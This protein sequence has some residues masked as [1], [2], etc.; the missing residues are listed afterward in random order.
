M[1][2]VNL[3]IGGVA[4][5]ILLLILKPTRP[6]NPN[7]TFRQQ[8]AKLDLVGQLCLMPSV[9]CLLLALQW[10]GSVYTWSSWRIIVLFT[11]FAVL[12]VAF[13]LAQ[14]LQGPQVA[15]IPGSVIKKRSIIAGMWIA[16]CL[17]WVM[18]IFVYYGTT[19]L[20]SLEFT[21]C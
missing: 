10:G 7:L 14:V 5:A 9:V 15:L 6:Q 8:L 3:P 21:S 20:F 17:A 19:H 16:A 12:A 13:V 11:V 2:P 1:Y 4:M 18:M